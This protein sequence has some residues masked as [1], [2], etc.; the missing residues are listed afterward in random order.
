MVL[1]IRFIA[2]VIICAAIHPDVLHPADL[3]TCASTAL[4]LT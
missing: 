2:T 4:V 3:W 1:C